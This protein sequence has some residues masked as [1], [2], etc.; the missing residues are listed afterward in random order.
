L[1]ANC[2]CPLAGCLSDNGLVSELPPRYGEQQTL[3]PSPPAPGSDPFTGV[4]SGDNQVVWPNPKGT[5]GGAYRQPDGSVIQLPP[6][7]PGD[8]GMFGQARI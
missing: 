6:I 3:L 2:A 8:L 4:P 1:A 5:I 7:A